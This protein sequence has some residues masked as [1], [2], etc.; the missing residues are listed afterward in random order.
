MATKKGLNRFVWDMRYPE[1]SKFEGMILWGGGTD[2]PRAV[3]GTYRARLTLNQEA[4]QE[5]EVVILPDPRAKATPQDLQAQ[6]TYLQEVRDKLTET[7]DAVRDIR[8]MRGQL[9]A[10][11]TPLKADA[12]YKDIVQAA[13][14]IDKKMT[15]IEE[16]LYQ[17]KNRSDQD[18]LN[19]PIKLNNKL[20]NLV[21]QVSDGDYRPTDQAQIVK[22][23]FTE[24][25]N[26]QLS[27]FREVREQDVPALNKLIRDKAVDAISV[28]KPKPVVPS[29]I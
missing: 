12:A 8:T 6:Y 25:I 29:S 24:Q 14:A 20:A 26:V 3:P 1:A 4:P 7:N 28:P 2:G 18:P 23:E 5:T 11:T 21:G 10:L 9:K 17:T 15:A 22:K 13:D 27:K 16:E 19:F